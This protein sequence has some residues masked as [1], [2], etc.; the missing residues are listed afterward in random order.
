MWGCWKVLL[1][2]ELLR[3]IFQLKGPKFNVHSEI[4]NLQSKNQFSM[5][6]LNFL[7]IWTNLGLFPRDHPSITHGVLLDSS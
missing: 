6:T 7:K 4:I 1:I 2:L 3:S 5:R